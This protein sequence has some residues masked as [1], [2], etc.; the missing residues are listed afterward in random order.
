MVFR[1]GRAEREVEEGVRGVGVTKGGQTFKIMNSPIHVIHLHGWN[2]I[3]S[4]LNKTH[5]STGLPR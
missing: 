5:P 3:F 4:A 1:I 2:A